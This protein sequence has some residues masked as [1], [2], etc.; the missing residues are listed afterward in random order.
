MSVCGIPTLRPFRAILLSF[1]TPSDRNLR[2]R[3]AHVGLFLTAV[4]PTPIGAQGFAV[5][6]L[7]REVME[8]MKKPGAS[9]GF[10]VVGFL[11]EL[12]SEID[13]PS[14]YLT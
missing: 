7:A 11:A 14:G 8:F 3:V 5:D 1:Q 10:R 9:L 12:G 2:S 6:E 4:K 13:I